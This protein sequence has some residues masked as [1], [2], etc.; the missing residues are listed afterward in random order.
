MRDQTQR[1]VLH[2]LL[3]S[4]DITT[5]DF[6]EKGYTKEEDRQG[7]RL[8]VQT[9]HEATPDWKNFIKRHLTATP[10]D[11]IVNRSCSFILLVNHANINYALTGGYGYLLIKPLADATFGLDVVMRLL[12]EA[13]ITALHQRNLKGSTRQIFR[14]V[15]GYNPLFDDD[16]VTRI[17][18]SLEGK[19]IFEGRRFRVTGRSSLTLRTARS[20]GDIHLVLQ[21]IEQVLIQAPK[22]TFPKG[23][24][25]VQDIHER[26]QLDEMMFNGFKE[27]WNNKATR[28]HLYLEFSEPLIQFRSDKFILTYGHRRIEIPDFDLEIIRDR[29]YQEGLTILDDAS[30]L[31]KLKVTTVDEAGHTLIRAVPIEKMLIC[32][33]ATNNTNYIRLDGEWLR[34]L[35]ELRVNLDERLKTVRVDPQLLPAWA[36]AQHPEELDYNRATAIAKSW[37]CLDQDFIQFQG[38]SR[39]ELCDQY[40]SQDGLFV[41]AKETWGAKSSYLF[42]QGVVA[43][44]FFKHDMAFRQACIQKWPTLFNT[45]SVE[46]PHTIVFG[47]A[48]TKAADDPTF[49][50]NMTYFAKLSLCD[51]ISRLREMDYNVILAPIK[52]L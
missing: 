47:I 4:V 26:E 11:V 35:D 43:A 8:F 41:H 32:E 45:Q 50:L 13:Q 23:F 3:N 12:D 48:D 14:A 34:I 51:A 5:L 37:A 31:N 29:F 46:Q 2:R 33:L 9:G 27:F 20:A 49:P 39:V 24:V 22:V 17:L 10:E 44:E 15:L 38:H 7:W 19:G 40:D 52:M 18:R 25:T 6:A 28:D 21:E 42:T 36:R 30:S 16:N 1:I